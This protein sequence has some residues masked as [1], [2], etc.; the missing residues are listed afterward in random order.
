MYMH[1]CVHVGTRARVFLPYL[2]LC[3]NVTRRWV[4]SGLWDQDA[5]VYWFRGSSDCNTQI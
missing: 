1:A 2:L 3:R 5:D 4:C